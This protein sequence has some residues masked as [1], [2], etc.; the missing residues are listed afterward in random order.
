MSKALP[1]LA[2]TTKTKLVV[3]DFDGVF[4]DNTVWT[5][6][7]GNESVRCWRSDGLGLVKLKNLGIKIY[8]LSTEENPVVAARCKKLKIPCIPGVND[9]KAALLKLM[10]DQ[11]VSSDNTIYVGNDINDVECLT[12]VDCSI[13]VADAYPAAL[14]V[15]KYRTTKPGGYGAVREICDWINNNYGKK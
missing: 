4:T 5:D 1:Q 9:K 7:H 13:V 12:L 14:K 8:V 6:Q 11:G 15:A 3:F 10:T 2:T